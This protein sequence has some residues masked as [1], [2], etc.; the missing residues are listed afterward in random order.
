[1][2]WAAYVEDIQ[3]AYITLVWKPQGKR[4]KWEDNRKLEIREAGYE[5]VN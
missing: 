1:M 5:S 2:K 3:N 4:L